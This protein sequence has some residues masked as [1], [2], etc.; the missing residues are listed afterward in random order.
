MVLLVLAGDDDVVHICKYI[1]ANLPFEYCFGESGEGGPGILETLRHSD[2]AIS[3]EGCYKAGAS[4][5][6][7]LHVYLVIAGE[8][9][10]ERHD[11]ASGRAIDYFVDPRQREIVLWAGLIETGEV[12]AHSPFPAFFLHHYNIGEPRGV[13]HWLDEFSL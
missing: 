3:A 12:Y 11:L 13:S 10:E 7:L 8:A 6:F 9:V 2:E 4:L 1:S 5:V